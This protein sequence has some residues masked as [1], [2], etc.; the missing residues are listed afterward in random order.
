MSTIIVLGILTSLIAGEITSVSPWCAEK[1]ARWSA[2]LW[3]TDNP[4]RAEIRAEELAAVIEAR[5][6]TSSSC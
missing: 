2:R 1:L 5:P 4:E 6:E 3:Y